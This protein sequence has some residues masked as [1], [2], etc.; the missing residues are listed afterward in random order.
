[1]TIN[2]TLVN[3]GASIKVKLAAD[4]GLITGSSQAVTLKNTLA[5]D[6][7]GGR[8]LDALVDIVADGANTASGS[9]LVYDAAQDKYIVKLLDL[10]GGSF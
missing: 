1:M 7:S 9:T 6:I 5:S 3:S 8:R 10:D 2:A 4:N